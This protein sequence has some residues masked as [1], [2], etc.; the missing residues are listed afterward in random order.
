MTH[1]NSLLP[2]PFCGSEDVALTN[3]RYY[4]DALTRRWAVIK[5][6]C[7]SCKASKQVADVEDEFLPESLVTQAVKAWN[8]RV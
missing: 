1:E 6:E 2:C 4:M 3:D 7:N 5:T 8:T